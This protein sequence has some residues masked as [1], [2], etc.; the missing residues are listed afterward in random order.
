MQKFIESN[1]LTYNGFLKY[2]HNFVLG[3]IPITCYYALLSVH[4]DPG[5]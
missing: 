4:Y 2:G 1:L 3:K 5:H